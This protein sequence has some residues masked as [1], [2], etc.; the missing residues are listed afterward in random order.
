L[1]NDLDVDAVT[2]DNQADANT[3]NAEIETGDANVGLT[4]VNT[5]NTNI[6]G[7]KTSEFDVYDDHSGDIVVDFADVAAGGTSASNTSTGANSNNT[8]NTDTNRS[9][10]I[11]NDNDATVMSDVAI[12]AVTGQNTTNKNTGDA[13]IETGDAN[14][15]ANVLNLVNNTVGAGAEILVATVNI[16]GNQAGDLILKD[17]SDGSGSQ[18]GSGCVA[19]GGTSG[20]YSTGSDSFNDANTTIN[21]DEVYLTNNSADVSNYVDVNANT[22]GNDASKNTDGGS[23][24][25]GDVNVS[26]E[27]TT[28]ANTTTNSDWWLVIVNEAGRW[29]GHIVGADGQTV[30]SNGTIDF[31]AVNDGTGAGSNNSASVNQ[32]NSTS[33]TQNNTADVDTK[34]TVNADTGN[35]TANKNTGSGD[36]ESGDV[37]VAANIVNF[38]NNNFSGGKVMIA[39]VNIFDDWTG[40]IYTPDQ[41]KLV[42]DSGDDMVENNNSET[43]I[44]GVMSGNHY[45][46]STENTQADGEVDEEYVHEYNYSYMSADSSEA[47]T[48]GATGYYTRRSVNPY[49]VRRVLGSVYAPDSSTVERIRANQWLVE[50][51]PTITVTPGPEVQAAVAY[52]NGMNPTQWLLLVAAGGLLAAGYGVRR[53]GSV[54]TVRV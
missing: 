24:K 54:M 13:S 12:D 35:N 20:N 19:N 41:Q 52:D 11:V 47:T 51:D 7:V 28:M 5:A 3:G 46:T 32:S 42:L 29:V 36:V 38:V 22:G 15:V 10:T 53:W 1:N 21:S 8:A 23:V 34:I 43:E 50:D 16:F 17:S 37:N 25:S 30:A 49:G 44:G 6:D 26:A 40:N 2:G 33:V 48:V 14:V 45:Q 39:F 27:A 31:G 18:C 4:V 9:L